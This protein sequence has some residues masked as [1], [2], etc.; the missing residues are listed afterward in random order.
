MILFA[1]EAGCQVNRMNPSRDLAASS[2]TEF[3]SPHDVSHHFSLAAP[4]EVRPV[5]DWISGLPDSW[6]CSD[7]LCRS[8]NHLHQAHPWGGNASGLLVPPLPQCCAYRILHILLCL[9]AL[10]PWTHA[11]NN[12]S[13][14]K[15]LQIPI[16]LQVLN[17]FGSVP[18]SSQDPFTEQEGSLLMSTTTDAEV[19]WSGP[20]IRSHPYLKQLCLR[21]WRLASALLPP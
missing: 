1:T 8:S 12:S 11:K 17:F 19:T 3:A 14:T 10:E 6:H 5:R 9:I 16:V 13:R 18:E 21:L 4:L 7:S 20:R 2:D 15:S